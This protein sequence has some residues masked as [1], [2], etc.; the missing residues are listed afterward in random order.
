MHYYCAPTVH[1]EVYHIAVWCTTPVH[2]CR[3]TKRKK[4]TSS[5]GSWTRAARTH[6]RTRVRVCVTHVRTRALH[7]TAACRNRKAITFVEHYIP[8]L[9]LNIRT[10]QSPAIPSGSDDANSA[11]G[12]PV[13]VSLVDDGTSVRSLDGSYGG[14]R[15]GASVVGEVGEGAGGNSTTFE[16]LSVTLAAEQPAL[17]KLAFL[18]FIS[19]LSQEPGTA[20]DPLELFP[21]LLAEL[22]RIARQDLAEVRGRIAEFIVL[23]CL[24]DELVEFLSGLFMSP[25]HYEEYANIL[26]LELTSETRSRSS[27]Y[28]SEK[29]DKIAQNPYF[30]NFS[31]LST[32]FH[33]S[34]HVGERMLA[35]Q[36]RRKPTKSQVEKFANGVGNKI[37]GL[38][39]G[40]F[41][42]LNFVETML[43]T[44][45]VLADGLVERGSRGEYAADDR[46][47]DYHDRYAEDLGRGRRRSPRC[48]RRA[49][50][51][52]ALVEDLV[53]ALIHGACLDAV[54]RDLLES[55]ADDLAGAL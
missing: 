50:G 34:I 46:Y 51:S 31:R 2:R 4:S 49:P 15:V 3:R 27:S 53:R 20:K 21:K 44:N 22:N 24:K 42:V 48:S 40:V 12:P 54:Y 19:T 26:C 14:S 30:G 41:T 18:N 28:S 33:Q 43:E 11:V 1:R 23:A 9:L 55:F 29:L 39:M 52:G 45:P 17:R 6:T 37:E 13:G 8:D 38:L 16:L 5:S 32:H 7:C 47:A 35:Y 25:T 36:L 10:L